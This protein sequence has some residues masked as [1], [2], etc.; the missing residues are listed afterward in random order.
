MQVKKV[1]VASTNPVK[2]KAALA[3]LQRMFPDEIFEAEPIS[4]PSG[5]ADQPMTDEETL[6]GAY[7]RV[8][9]A[10]AAIAGADF[11]IGLEGGVAPMLGELA[12]FAWIVVCSENKT[13]K[14]RSGTFFLPKQVT[15]L[16]A[17]GVE[18]GT[19]NDQI[20]SQVNSKQK[21]GAV[22]ILT[23]G[24]LDRKELYEQ[25]VLLALVPFKTQG[26]Y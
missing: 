19:A 4:V 26:L 23:D 1:V 22:G 10:R 14:A 13:G 21:G 11:Y 2:V 8:K 24:V 3:G 15:E 20:F 18:L 25:A 12:T 6:Q 9:N 17:Q 7:N 16:V 5:V